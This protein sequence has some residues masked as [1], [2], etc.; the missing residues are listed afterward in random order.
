MKGDKRRWIQ[1]LAIGI[2]LAICLLGG[3][4][5]AQQKP[6]ETPV[7]TSVDKTVGVSRE[8]DGFWAD[9]LSYIDNTVETAISE[10]EIPGAVV[11][12]GRKDRTVY[13]KA[14]GN[15]SLEPKVEPMTKDTIFD[16]SSLTKVMATVPSVMLLVEDGILRLGDPVRRYL[17]R[18]KGEGKN[19]ILV[20]QLMTH[21]SG[22]PADFDL[23]KKW[24]GYEAALEELWKVRPDFEPEEEF[25]YSDINFIAL[26]EIVHVE[27][28]KTLDEF[29]QEK[30]FT[31]LGMTDTCFRPSPDMVKRTAPTET[32]RSTLRYLNG[33]GSKGSMDTMLRGEVHDPTAWRMGGVAGH[34]GLFSSAKDIAIYAGMLVGGGRHEGERFFSPLTVR[35]MSSRQSPAGSDQVRGYGWD[36]H[37]DYSSPRGDIF[38]EGYGHTGFTGTSLW[39][40]PPTA[41]YIIILSNR[42]HPKGGKNINHLRSTVAN[43]VAAAIADCGK[44]P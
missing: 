3:G 34:A 41:T 23:S 43:I 32:R 2:A 35:A 40:H 31:P 17:P 19:D 8:S 29:S 1:S 33:Q 28:G 27:S 36:I 37:S 15:R 11:L 16:V 44:M 12:V 6:P 9:R 38:M 42:V 26:G 25:V 30:I 18:F 4:V 7:E 13:F 39:I 24:F 20:R 10:G 14:F 22:L 21:Y 5:I